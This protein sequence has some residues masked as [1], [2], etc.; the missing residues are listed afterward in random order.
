MN[1]I[2]H[3]C[4]LELHQYGFLKDKEGRPLYYKKRE[5]GTI[6]IFCGVDHSLADH[7][8]ENGI[9]IPPFI[10]LTSPIPPSG[11]PSL[12]NFSKIR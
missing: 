9:E 4:N 1:L 3:I 12:P 7:C 2:C 5:D 8:I 6:R 11:I 10:K